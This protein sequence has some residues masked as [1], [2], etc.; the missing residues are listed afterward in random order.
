M[1]HL[2]KIYTICKISYFLSLVLN[3]L[4]LSFFFLGGGGGGGWGGE[5]GEHYKL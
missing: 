1:I 3:E 2:I 4:I 5:G